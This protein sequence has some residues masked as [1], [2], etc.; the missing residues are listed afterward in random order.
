MSKKLVPKWVKR[1]DT[2]LAF[3][4]VLGGASAVL[5]SAIPDSM[6]VTWFSEHQA[7]AA[8][9]KDDTITLAGS[10][11]KNTVTLLEGKVSYLRKEGRAL[12]AVARRYK[13]NGDH[14][15]RLQ[16]DLEENQD[17]L[18]DAEAKLKVNRGH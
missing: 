5:T 15:P 6:R 2:W 17:N 11:K 8:V 9:H 12:R 16:E 4:I 1:W 13:E 14:D 18:R 3:V 10:I 7:L